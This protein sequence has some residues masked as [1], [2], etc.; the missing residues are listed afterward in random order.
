LNHD[1]V[2]KSRNP[3]VFRLLERLGTNPKVY[4]MSEREWVRK[5]GDS[6]LEGEWDK[7]K[8]HHG[9]ASHD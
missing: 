8:N 9:S 5:L 2:G 6:Y 3:K 4:Y 7:V 1:V